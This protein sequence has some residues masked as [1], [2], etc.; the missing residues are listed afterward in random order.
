[1]I[2]FIKLKV[3]YDNFYDKKENGTGKEEVV[4]NITY[5]FQ[6]DLVEMSE[7]MTP[8]IDLK[9]AYQYFERC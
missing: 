3:R 9:T 2:P 8:M 4:G 7:L 6:G 1:M 5:R